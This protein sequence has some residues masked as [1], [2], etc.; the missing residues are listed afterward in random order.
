MH[1]VSAAVNAVAAATPP[2]MAAVL[3]LTNGY[4]GALDANSSYT[5]T[6]VVL[7]GLPL[8]PRLQKSPATKN[9]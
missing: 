4:G 5:N 9:V 1:T 7:A 2:A 8:S 6:A 3:D